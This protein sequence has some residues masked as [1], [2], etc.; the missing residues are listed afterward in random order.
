MSHTLGTPQQTMFDFSAQGKPETSKEIQDP[1][2]HNGHP[3][4]QLTSNKFSAPLPED[5]ELETDN[6]FTVTSLSGKPLLAAAAA[7]LAKRNRRKKSNKVGFDYVVLLLPHFI[8]VNGVFIL[9]THA[10]R[11]SGELLKHFTRSRCRIVSVQILLFCSVWI[12]LAPA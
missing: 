1:Q 12:C 7:R 8:H 10:V 4:P 9:T 11:D 2:A 6:Q 5:D 3:N